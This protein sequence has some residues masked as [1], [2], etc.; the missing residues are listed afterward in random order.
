[1]IGMP[2]CA[3]D[4]VFNT[5]ELFDGPDTLKTARTIPHKMA[6]GMSSRA[7]TIVIKCL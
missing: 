7:I 3:D 5:S 2:G 1:M 4:I 6:D